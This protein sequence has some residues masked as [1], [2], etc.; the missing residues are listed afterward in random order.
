MK[1]PHLITAMLAGVM[2]TN[3]NGKVL[4]E[5]I[6]LTPDSHDS[7]YIPHGK[8]HARNK[9]SSISQRQVRKAKRR[10]FANGFTKAHKK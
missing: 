4:M 2:P 3:E 5:S 6:T 9:V 7:T 8:R 1:T 10:A